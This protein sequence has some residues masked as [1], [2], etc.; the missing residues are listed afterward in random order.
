M[1][2]AGVPAHGH[3]RSRAHGRGRGAGHPDSHDVAV[4]IAN[5][6]H[7]R[8]VPFGPLGPGNGHL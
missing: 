2:V 8:R 1:G 3:S 4:G 7:A 5:D 6:Q